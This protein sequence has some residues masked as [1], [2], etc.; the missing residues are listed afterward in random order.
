MAWA[1][2]TQGTARYDLTASGVAD[3]VTPLPYAGDLGEAAHANADAWRGAIETADQCSRTARNQAQEAFVAAVAE[4]YGVASDQV[5][6][7]MGASLA[8]T[9]VMLSMVRPGDHVIVERPTYEALHRVPELLGANVSRLDRRFDDGWAVVPDRLARI[10]TPRTR[11]IVLT[12]L[13]NPSGVAIDRATLTE[14]T[15]L[16]ARVGAF[17]LVDEV[18]L[19]YCFPDADDAELAPACRIADNCISWSSTTKCFGFSALRAGWIVAGDPQA[20]RALRTTTDYLFVDPPTASMQL[21]RRVLA[22]AEALTSHAAAITADGL[23][24]VDDW[25]TREKRVGW[26]RPRAGICGALRLPE[27]MQDV[28]FAAHLRERYD[29][30]VVPGTFFESPGVVRMGFGLPRPTLEEALT[31]ITAALDDL[32]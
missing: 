31:N 12:N 10:L 20:S 7:T 14:I 18:Y 3:T 4:R 32:T 27:L 16:A 25:L 9:H 23:A 22:E 2:S 28:A 29:T 24:A 26:V 5:T 19:D 6:P 21:G 30:Q 8:I 11:A 15:D 13:H 1:K 17:V